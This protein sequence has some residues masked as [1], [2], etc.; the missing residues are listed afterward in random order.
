MAAIDVFSWVGLDSLM[1][2]EDGEYRRQQRRSVM[3]DAVRI[4][5][6]GNT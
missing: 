3:A 5:W 6:S 2:T 4:L 1:V